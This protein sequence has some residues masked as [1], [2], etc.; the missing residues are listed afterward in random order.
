MS[1]IN[2]KNSVHQAKAA[3]LYDILQTE[4]TIRKHV[5]PLQAFP[6]RRHSHRSFKPLGD[7]LY[8]ADY[9]VKG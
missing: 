9:P 5:E 3:E 1:H 2:K 6:C 8:K 7:A 4:G